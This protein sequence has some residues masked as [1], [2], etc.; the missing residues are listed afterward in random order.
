MSIDN[1]VKNIRSKLSEMDKS[2]VK[3]ALF[4]QPGAGKSSLINKIVGKDI[5]EVDVRLT[6][7]LT[8]H[9]MKLMA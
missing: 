1:E 4:G 5:A 3:V 7:L 6:Q 2:I 8:L 9:G